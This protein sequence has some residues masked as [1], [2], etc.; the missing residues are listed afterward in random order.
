MLFSYG[1]VPFELS[2]ALLMV[3]V[4]GAVGV[5]RGN[6]RVKHKVSGGPLGAATTQPGSAGGDAAR[7]AARPGPH[8]PGDLT[9]AREE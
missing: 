9:P 7:S 6:H 3:A 4:L 1:V 8:L 5:A 2:S